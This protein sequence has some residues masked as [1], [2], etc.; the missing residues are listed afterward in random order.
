MDATVAK[1]YGLDTDLKDR[2]DFNV[3]S[4]EKILQIYMKS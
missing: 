2:D 1:P 4:L 3:K